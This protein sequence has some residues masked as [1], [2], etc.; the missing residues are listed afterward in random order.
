MKVNLKK[1]ISTAVLGLVLFTTSLPVW[2]GRVETNEVVVLGSVSRYAYGSMVGGRDSGDSTQYI[3][4]SSGQEGN[5]GIVWCFAMD[6][7]GKSLFCSSTDSRAVALVKAITDFSQLAFSTG[8]TECFQL[9]VHN[10]SRF[11]R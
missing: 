1:L 7:T 4:C 8:G 2:A 6:K 9:E 5:G 11:L 10:Y 3:G